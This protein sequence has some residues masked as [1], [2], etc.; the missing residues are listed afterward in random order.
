MNPLELS[1]QEIIRRNSMAALREMGIEPYPAAEYPVDAYSDEIRS[2]FRD[3]DSAEPRRVCV[4]GRIMGRR[5]MGKASFMELQD[6]R[7]RIQV[8]VSRDEICPGEDK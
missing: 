2:N 6:S 3:D 8:Y 1:E 4:A 5:I 7:G